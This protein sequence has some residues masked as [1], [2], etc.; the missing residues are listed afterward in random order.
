[1]SGAVTDAFNKFRALQRERSQ[2]QLSGPLVELLGVCKPALVGVSRAEQVEILR[3]VAFLLGDLPGNQQIWAWLKHLSKQADA[4]LRDA[5]TTT[6][7]VLIPDDPVDD[8]DLV[9]LWSCIDDVQTRW[10]IAEAYTPQPH[11]M[12]PHFVRYL[13]GP[14]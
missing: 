10:I 6:F 9:C 12:L 11:K 5:L 2:E 7:F 13:S 3:E 8:R 14:K 4:Q 1:M